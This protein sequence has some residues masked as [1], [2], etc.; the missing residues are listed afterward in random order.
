[1]TQ[2]A[3]PPNRRAR[4]DAIEAAVF[5]AFQDLLDRP[6]SPSEC[7][8]WTG[9]LL[10]GVPLRESLGQLETGSEHLALRTV[11]NKCRDIEATGLFDATWYQRR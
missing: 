8:E 5:E 3:P 6:P 7:M 11:R 10:R 4:R 1:M 2:D 9:K